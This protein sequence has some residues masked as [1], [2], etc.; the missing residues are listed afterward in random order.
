MPLLYSTQKGNRAVYNL[1]F[2]V[3]PNDVNQDSGRD[4]AGGGLRKNGLAGQVL[5]EAGHQRKNPDAFNGKCAG[6]PGIEFAATACIA[7]V[8]P[9]GSA[10]AR[11]AEAGLFDKGFKEHRAIAVASMPV[12]G[13]AAGNQAEEFGGQVPGAHPRE[14]EETGVIYDE[15]ETGLALGR[16][17][18]DE[19]VAWRGFP[20]GGPEA[21]QREQAFFR[22]GEVPLLRAGQRPVAQIVVPVDVLI[23]QE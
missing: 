12:V 21:Q 22:P 18:A 20:G 1:R 9:V 17:P 3:G 5:S 14:D 8:L 7:K 15:V 13:Q 23:P 4:Q 2:G 11:S 19:L 6:M 10:I 16:R